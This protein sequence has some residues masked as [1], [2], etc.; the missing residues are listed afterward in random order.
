VL[1]V[2]PSLAQKIIESRI[3]TVNGPMAAL[4]PSEQRMW[5][6]SLIQAVT[7]MQKSGFLPIVLAPEASARI[8][9][10]NSTDREIPDLVVLSIPEISKDIQVE[11]IGEIKLEQDK[12]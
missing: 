9:I 4:E 10:K 6:R 3:D 12:N 1:T 2:E 11:V 7:T 8:L 5:I